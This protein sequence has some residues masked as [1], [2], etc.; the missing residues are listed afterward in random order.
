M[1]TSIY[2]MTTDE[3]SHYIDALIQRQVMAKPGTDRI[4]AVN[5]T[6]AAFAELKRRAPGK[7]SMV[8]GLQ[9]G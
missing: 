1:N 6:R 8:L 2:S 3:L 7:R 5:A 4:E 9:A